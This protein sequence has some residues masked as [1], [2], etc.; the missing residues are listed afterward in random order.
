MRREDGGL[1]SNVRRIL[2][3]GAWS[4][5]ILAQLGSASGLKAQGSPTPAQ[6]PR[7]GQWNQAFN[8]E[9]NTLSPAGGPGVI[10]TDPMVPFQGGTR[11]AAP[12]EVPFNAVHMALIPR[13]KD[14]GKVIVWNREKFE[15][16][17][18]GVTNGQDLDW[19][20]QTWAI[21]DPAVN[22]TGPRF[23]NFLLPLHP[24]QYVAGTGRVV[25]NLFCA[26]HCWSPYGDLVVVG[27]DS[28]AGT[29]TAM[30]MLYRPDE[31]GQAWPVLSPVL[32][33]TNNFNGTPLYG[34]AHGK[35]IYGPAL[36]H[37]RYYPTV[38]LSSR[39]VRTGLKEV[40][41]VF[42]GSD[43]IGGGFGLNPQWNTYEAL[44]MLDPNAPLTPVGL[45][46]D[47]IGS[48]AS[49]TYVFEGPDNGT[50][51][52]RLFE[53][54]P[55]MHWVGSAQAFMSGYAP[56]SSRVGHENPS[57][58][59]GTWIYNV[60]AT[61]TGQG[62]VPSSFVERHDGASVLF[63]RSGPLTNFLGRMGGFDG[64]QATP[65]T[66]FL[67]NAAGPS[68]T[69]WIKGPSMVWPRGWQNAVIL[70][71]ASILVVGGTPTKYAP[72][73]STHWLEVARSAELF[74]DGQWGLVAPGSTPRG[75]HATAVLLPDGRVMVGGGEGRHQFNPPASFDYEIY[76]PWYMTEPRPSITSITSLSGS[77]STLPP[78][79]D[80]SVIVDN[81]SEI[82]V[83]LQLPPLVSP[84]K[85][86]LMSP[87]SMTH[88]SDMHAR[89][90]EMEQTGVDLAL[91]TGAATILCTIP[92]ETLAP[93][94][95]YMM[96]AMTSGGV[97]SPAGW[98]QIH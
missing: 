14:R 67:T 35:W 78:N 9:V 12:F 80:G 60:G 52:I 64:V 22:P 10:G 16:C 51:Q 41:L 43:V 61:S 70:P 76:S 28:T 24:I 17:P 59:P 56:Q 57:T 48:A 15:L 54:Y 30:V 84:G 79:P 69:Q 92:S 31:V 77:S 50:A 46:K 93:R 58:I 6:S 63:A 2:G 8:H 32:G 89:Y 85:I 87:G 95:Y 5:W 44:V 13:G 74:K 91:E 97:P 75:Y 81:G 82:S 49:P 1:A 90:V 72:V 73:I 25:E 83:D 23:Q 20:F 45:A 19:S 27:G 38:T 71:D 65:T 7:P 29:G 68:G 62:S 98:I 34:G 42:G 40:A 66:E 21:V 94:G 3:G 96:F 86:V 88:H 37:D 18:N 11:I 55:R 26:G 4:V 36:Q 47:F 39:L 53:E 33:W